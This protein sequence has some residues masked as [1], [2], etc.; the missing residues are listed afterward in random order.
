M[1]IV[2]AL[3]SI[4]VLLVIFYIILVVAVIFNI[5]NKE[6]GLATINDFNIKTAK[7][8]R[9]YNSV[10]NILNKEYALSNGFVSS[11]DKVFVLRKDAAASLSFLY[12]KKN[13]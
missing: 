11:D 5:V 10:I 1:H 6:E 7:I 13:E 8:E 9:E 2:H 12:D 3:L 4:L